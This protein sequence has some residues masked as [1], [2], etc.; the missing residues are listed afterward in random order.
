LPQ[1]IFLKDWI[2]ERGLAAPNTL[3]FI[4]GLEADLEELSRGLGIQVKMMVES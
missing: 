1:L 3:A 2:K 4:K